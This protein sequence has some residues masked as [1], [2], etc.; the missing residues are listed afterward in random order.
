VRIMFPPAE[1]E[2][3]SLFHHGLWRANSR[4]LATTS[5]LPLPVAT[6]ESR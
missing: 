5:T 2:L 3:A 6:T 4:N 1:Q